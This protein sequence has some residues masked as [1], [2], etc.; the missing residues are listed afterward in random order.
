MPNIDLK[1]RKELIQKEFYALE[2]SCRLFSLISQ[3]ISKIGILASDINDIFTNDKYEDFSYVVFSINNDKKRF[4]NKEVQ[5][6]LN[7]NNL[8]KFLIEGE[9]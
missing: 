8:M 9:L 5:T 6:T 1:E 7:Q 3:Y 4:G 2:R